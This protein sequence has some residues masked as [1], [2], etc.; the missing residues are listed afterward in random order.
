[1]E[2]MPAGHDDIMPNV[3]DSFSWSAHGHWGDERFRSHPGTWM[4]GR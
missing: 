1:M 3:A 4:R 2:E